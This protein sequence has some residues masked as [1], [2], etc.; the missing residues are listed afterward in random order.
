VLKTAVVLVGLGFASAL[1]CLPAATSS[2]V[3]S[4]EVIRRSVAANNRDWNAQP[5]F[6]YRA[7]EIKFKVDDTG[8]VQ[9]RQSKTYQVIMLDGTPY[10]RLIGQDNEPLSPSAAHEEAEKLAEESR[11]RQSESPNAHHS[12]VAKYRDQRADEH[13]LMQQM[14]DAFHFKLLGEEQVDGTDCLHFE[15]IPNPDYRPPVEKARVLTGMRGQIWI[16]KH[17]YHWAKVEAQVTE[18]VEFGF[19][20]AKVK[21]GTSFELE[22]APVGGVWLPKRFVESVNASVLGLYGYRS[23][24]ETDYSNYTESRLI[25]KAN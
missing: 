13:L 17:D 4:N 15:A 24:M 11:N 20:V 23:K 1:V 16:E 25:A 14:I 19:F 7:T 6:S 22:Q 8:K 12:R 3:N 2:S 21:P 9:S 10:R 18:P 5:Q